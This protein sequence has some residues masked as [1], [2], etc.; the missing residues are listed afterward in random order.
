MAGTRA[1]Y[2]GSAQRK[3]E[4]GMLKEKATEA[5]FVFGAVSSTFNRIQRKW[6]KTARISS[7]YCFEVLA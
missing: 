6:K 3:D 1:A 2:G 4:T 5:T 7:N